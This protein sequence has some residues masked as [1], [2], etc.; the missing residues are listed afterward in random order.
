[1]RTT[2]IKRASPEALIKNAL[3]KNPCRSVVSPPVALQEATCSAR[4]ADRVRQNRLNARN[5][6]RGRS[7]KETYRETA[8]SK[9]IQAAHARHTAGV[10]GKRCITWG[11]TWASARTVGHQGVRTSMPRE[12]C[13]TQ[14]YKHYLTLHY[15]AWHYRT[16]HYYIYIY[17]TSKYSSTHEAV[18]DVVALHD[19]T[20]QYSTTQYIT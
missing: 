7:F 14:P 4:A 5:K 10:V 13:K 1:M 18:Q 9:I 2:V 17:I 6:P 16:F 11:A 19:M 3:H 15:I 12:S 8:A 20:L